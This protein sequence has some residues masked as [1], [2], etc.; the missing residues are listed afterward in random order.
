MNI[1]D[2]IEMMA[3]VIGV[4]GVYAGFRSVHNQMFVQIFADYTRRYSDIIDLVPHS[5]RTGIKLADLGSNEQEQ[6]I[7]AM[8]KYMNLCSEEFFLVETSRLDKGTWA[9]WQKGI[10]AT[11]TD[12]PSFAEVW[13]LIK[14]EYAFYPSFQEMIL[15]LLSPS[16]KKEK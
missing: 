4:I 15:G 10:K 2:Y 16:P 5:A 6:F 7:K 11:L 1:G 3:V 9:M 14:A 13:D 8:R 12:Y